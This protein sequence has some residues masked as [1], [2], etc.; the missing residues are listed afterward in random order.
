MLRT[1][2]LACLAVAFADPRLAVA[3]SCSL[4]WL[5]G[6]GLP[7]VDGTV[8]CSTR[9]DPDGPGPLGERLVIGGQ[10]RAVGPTAALNVA[11][12]DPAT[13]TWDRLDGI[14]FP[15]HALAAASSGALYMAT[16]ETWFFVTQGRVRA[17]VGGSWAL[18][19]AS[20]DRTPNVLAVMP[21][22]DVVAG[23]GF[24]TVGT[25]AAKGLARWNGSSWQS[26]G[27]LTWTSGFGTAGGIATGLLVLPN[28]DLLLNGLFSTVGP[29][30]ASGVAVFDGVSWGP[31]GLSGA[32]P[33]DYCHAAA[34]LANGS[35]VAAPRSVGPTSPIREWNGSSWAPLP[36]S[37]NGPNGT[38]GGLVALANG[39]LVAY[40]TFGIA[41]LQGSSWSMSAP[42]G[43]PSLDATPVHTLSTVTELASG[44][45]VV[46]GVFVRIGTVDAMHLVRRTG[47]TWQAVARGTNDVV[48]AI[49]ALPDGSFVAGGRFT[50][51]GGTPAERLA[52]FD[53]TTWAPIQGAH[54]PVTD[55]VARPD[56]EVIALGEFLTSA[57]VSP[58][59]VARIQGNS[60]SPLPGAAFW[61]QTRPVRLARADNGQVW[62]ACIQN[63][64]Q[65]VQ[66]ARWDGVA[67]NTE[68]LPLTGVVDAITDAANGDVVLGGQMV[69]VPTG[70]PRFLVRWNGTT[71]QSVGTGLD[72][73]VRAVVRLPG[74]DLVAGGDFTSP[75]TYLARWDGASWRPVG[76][77][78]YAPVRALAVLPDADVLV[79]AGAL[80][81]WD[82]T[83]WQSAGYGA[84]GNLHAIAISRLGTIAIAGAFQTVGIDTPRAYFAQ[85]QST[86]PASEAAYGA[87]CA[88]TGAV[89]ALSVDT[90]PWIGGAMRW[91][92]SGLPGQA[93]VAPVLGLAQASLPLS[94]VL[95]IAAA[96][97]V[98][99]TTSDLL[100]P[101]V[102]APG[103]GAPGSAQAQVSIPNAVALIGSS[104]YEQVL[105]FELDALGNLVAFTSSNG[106]ALTI[107]HL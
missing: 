103:T 27:D 5:P 36:S 24:A 92:A 71:A 37:P 104:F 83:A 22:G 1:L 94:S 15:V 51:I 29:S 53:G 25:V 48:D 43:L 59:V 85:L 55:L 96:G 45:L 54:G 73:R 102:V 41:T 68:T 74:G 38:L 65:L 9:W 46:G 90:L 35:L 70:Q 86:C 28:G 30:V 78:L 81:R 23:G 3:Q 14:D 56:A 33:L 79:D 34:R 93:V 97:C 21:N 47:N 77:L 42:L 4:E 89:V 40:G 19:G 44:D 101:L 100:L 72:D 32:F 82:G 13:Q 57:T 106:L 11:C 6:D 80:L 17:W 10:F 16:E 8:L 87:G 64:S 60:V 63:G 26:M 91:T 62:I 49:A 66:V 2:R 18:L 105:V 107:G 76:S 20:F 95:P 98:L 52:T 58:F 61:S 67:L 7:G 99:L 84:P 69:D 75:E 39:D 50:T 31:L 12:Y 88:G